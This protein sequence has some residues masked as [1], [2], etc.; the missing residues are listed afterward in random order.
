MQKQVLPVTKSWNEH[1]ESTSDTKPPVTYLFRDRIYGEFLAFVFYTDNDGVLYEGNA[2][3]MT[4]HDEFR[5]GGDPTD[6]A[7]LAVRLVIYSANEHW[8]LEQLDIT[9]ATTELTV[10]SIEGETTWQRIDVDY[11]DFVVGDDR[12]MLQV[13]YK[14]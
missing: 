12:K 2:E 5:I 11:Y 14:Q 13:S 3:Y 10:D 9:E 1:N 7:G 4:K 6:E 8:E